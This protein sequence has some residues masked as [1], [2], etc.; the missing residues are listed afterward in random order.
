[1]NSVKSS[2]QRLDQ[3][4]RGKI[5]LRSNETREALWAVLNIRVVSLFRY[6]VGVKKE[7]VPVC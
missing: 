5:V 6:S 2:T 7:G 3:F 4:L 1:M